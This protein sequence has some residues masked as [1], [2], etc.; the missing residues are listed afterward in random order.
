MRPNCWHARRGLK[1]PPE[2]CDTVLTLP[3]LR[4]TDS[5]SCG[6]V[7]RD[8]AVSFFGRRA[9]R[10]PPSS[11]P[12]DGT[13]PLALVAEFRLLGFHVQSGEMDLIDLKHHT[14]AGRPVVVLTRLGDE[15]H[16]Q[17]VAGVAR[18]RVRY[19]CP[20]NGPGSEPAAA[21]LARWWDVGRDVRY[22]QFGL[23]VWP[24]EV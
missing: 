21:F 1:P 20:A 18:G 5:H 13:D 23:A 16:Y 4:Q 15:G 10:R 19:Q 2:E 24:Q 9:P 12:V 7:A 3:D 6:R 14:A 22:H 17:V 11:S 8:V